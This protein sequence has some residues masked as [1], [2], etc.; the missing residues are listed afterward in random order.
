MLAREQVMTAID[1]IEARE[2]LD[3]RGNPTIEVMFVLVERLR[4]ARRRS[5]RRLHRRQEAVELRDGDRSRFGGK[6]VLG[7]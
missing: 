3:S 5:V 2:I 7:P 1:L 6:G 4:R